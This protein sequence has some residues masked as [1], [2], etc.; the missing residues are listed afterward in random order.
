MNIQNIDFKELQK[1]LEKYMSFRIN[2]ETR[3]IDWLPLPPE[4]LSREPEE[5]SER[6]GLCAYMKEYRDAKI[7]EELREAMRDERERV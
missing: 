2:E 5:P 1:K 7:P 6:S 4:D 3:T